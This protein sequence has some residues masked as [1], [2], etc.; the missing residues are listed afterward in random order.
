MLFNPHL[1]HSSTDELTPDSSTDGWKD[2]SK[3]S[4]TGV[5]A[6]VKG[7]SYLINVFKS[8]GDPKDGEAMSKSFAEMIDKAEEK[9]E[10]RVV[11]FCCDNDRG[12]QEGR[13]M[14]G[15][16]QLHLFIPPCMAHQV[17]TVPNVNFSS[18]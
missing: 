15:V 12:S 16:T 10:C 1:T 11:T 5:N 7:K 9:Y 2:C 17:R 6:S 4:I 13:K 14:L 8:T 18:Y 3:D